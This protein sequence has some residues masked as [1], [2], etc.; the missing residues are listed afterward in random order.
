MQ[1]FGLTLLGI[2]FVL[3]KLTNHIDWSWWLVTAP[4]W[5]VPALM[6]VFAAGVEVLYRSIPKE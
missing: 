6:T 3:L 4:F 1:Y 2:L 5:V